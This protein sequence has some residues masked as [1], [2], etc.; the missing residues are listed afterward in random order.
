MTSYCPPRAFTPLADDRT[1]FSDVPRR[2]VARGFLSCPVPVIAD[3][4]RR[5]A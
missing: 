1:E 3:D 2:R 4:P 5:A